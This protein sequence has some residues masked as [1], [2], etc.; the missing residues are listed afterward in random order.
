M[1]AINKN[2]KQITLGGEA[3]RLTTSKI[4]T[5]AITMA[6]VMLL[7]RFRT[8][9]EYGTYSQLLLIINLFTTLLMLGL[10]ASI[11]FFLARA[12]TQAEKKR[13]LSVY[14]T[15]S[16]ILSFIIGFLLVLAVPFIEAY[17]HNSLIG[18]FYYFLAV[19]PWSSIIGSSIENILVV[20]KKTSY[21]MQYRVIHSFA[22]L[23]TVVVIQWL[24]L[25]FSEYMM[26]YI[27]VNSLF[28]LSVYVIASKLTGGMDLLLDKVLILEIFS[29]SI[30]I[31]LA[32]V[33]GTLNTEIDKLLIGYLMNTEQMAI[34]TNAAK[35]LPLTII[36][37]SITAVLLPQAVRMIKANKSQ[38]AVRLWGYASEL[39][40][41]VIAVFVAGVFT[42][43]EDVMTILYSAKYLPGV[44]VF[45]IYTLNL[46]LRIT[47][48][49][50][51]L[52]AYGKTKII[53]WCS[54]LS[55]ILNMMLNPLFYWLFGMIGPA[56][57]TFLAILLIQQLQL[58]LTAVVTQISFWKV[59]PWKHSVQILL[60]NI[61]FA[62]VFYVIKHLLPLDFYVG[63]VFE[64]IVLGSVWFLI[65]MLMMRKKM[66]FAWHKLNAEG[67]I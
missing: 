41:I 39:S 45:R 17:F 23:A 50:M 65:Y 14:Y 10:P 18:K 20:Y 44:T 31:G 33:I 21:L 16:T 37:S 52:N 26:A 48:F 49:G 67:S 40:L 58:K 47:Y 64:S 19:F 34:Y 12:E 8:F 42:Y 55:L 6:T 61:C 9:E 4:I 54:V 43:A 62:F 27:V 25:G 53:F 51:V 46:L 35:E 38:E 59:F 3:I 60:I 29:F 13:F 7:S 22:I 57:A 32:S 15:L 28:A 11:N 30:P 5:M 66:L 24:E 1:I 63:S 56:V 2:R 36:A